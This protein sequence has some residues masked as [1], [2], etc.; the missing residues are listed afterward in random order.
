MF[1][2]IYI[3]YFC[4][5]LLFM[6]LRPN[7]SMFY[8]SMSKSNVIF[9]FMVKK[10]LSMIS[11]RFSYH[12]DEV[13]EKCNWKPNFSFL[14]IFFPHLFSGFLLYKLH[15]GHTDTNEQHPDKAEIDSFLAMSI[16][17]RV[18]VREKF[19]FEQKFSRFVSK[20]F[21]QN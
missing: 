9:R 2:K 6:C 15:N 4:L 5:H 14:T 21:Y 1:G 3:S 12:N 10:T 18:I 7:F 17:L 11:F 20:K 19:C 8:A 16:W 13:W